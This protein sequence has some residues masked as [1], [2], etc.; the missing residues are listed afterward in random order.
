MVVVA[1]RNSAMHYFASFSPYF[2]PKQYIAEKLLS[3][4]QRGVVGEGHF[5]PDERI[6]HCHHHTTP[7]HPLPPHPTPVSMSDA[8]GGWGVERTSPTPRELLLRR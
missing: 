5:I 4:L 7:S 1:A 2:E 8:W 3:L 6:A